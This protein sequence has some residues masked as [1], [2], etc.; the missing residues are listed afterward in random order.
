MVQQQRNWGYFVKKKEEK[1]T[2]YEVQNMPLHQPSSRGSACDGG[3]QAGF[4]SISFFFCLKTFE[5]H[6]LP[7][8]F[9]CVKGQPGLTIVE[10][11]GKLS[12]R[13]SVTGTIEMDGVRVPLENM[14]PLAKGLKVR[15]EQTTSSDLENDNGMMLSFVLSLVVVFASA[16][17]R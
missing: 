16:T 6:V 5:R 17:C 12:L 11:E 13:A 2:L 14:L 7:V 10:I 8:V 1:I 9:S 4:R 3:Q 15:R